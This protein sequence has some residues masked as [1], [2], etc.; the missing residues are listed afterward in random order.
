MGEK[1]YVYHIG[2][3]IVPLG[4]ELSNWIVCIDY[5]L[6]YRIAIFRFKLPDHLASKYNLTLEK[7]I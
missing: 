2:D 5:D 7:V 1:V 6:Y 4:D 3:P